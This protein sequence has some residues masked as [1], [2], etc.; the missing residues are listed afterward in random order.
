MNRIR[1]LIVIFMMPTASS[2]S[3]GSPVRDAQSVYTQPDGST[4]TVRLY[5]DEWLKICT[6]ADGCTVTKGNDGWWCYGIYDEEGKIHNS[7]YHIGDAAPQEII[8]ASRK[9]PFDILIQKSMMRRAAILDNASTAIESIRRQAVQTKTGG[10]TD[11]KGLALLVQFNDTE[12]TYGKEDFIRLLNQEG[13]NQTGSAKDYYEDQFGENWEFSFDVSEIITLPWPVS[14]YGMNDDD[15]QDIRPWEM[16]KD[17]CVAADNDIDFSQYD[18]DDDGKV[19]NVYIFYAG[20]SESEHTDQP[21][22]IWPH[23]YYIYSGTPG[24]NLVLDGKR[25]DRYACS[26]EITG[27]RSLTG[28]GSFCHEYGHTFGLMDL[29]D[30]DYDKKG[31]WAAGTW[32]STSLMDGGNYNNDSAT[33]PNFNCIERE[34]LGLSN[35]IILEEGNSY[36]IDPIHRNGL[37]FRLNTDTEG[38]YYLFE[39]RSNEGWDKYIGGRGMLVYHIDKNLKEDFGSYTA[40]KWKLNTINSDVT[41]QCADLIEADGRSDEIHSLADLQTNISGIFFP[42]ND[43]TAITPDGRP[44]LKF[45]SGMSS[46]LSITGI[47]LS[48]DN[49]ISF[50][51][52]NKDDV[53]DI[54]APA[55][56]SFTTFPSA[57]LI[58][59]NSSDT[60]LSGKPVVQWKKAS[61]TSYKTADAAEYDTGKYVCLIQGLESGNVSYEAVIRFRAGNSHDGKSQRVSFM[62]KRTPNITWPYI[63]INNSQINAKDGFPLYI[64][65][66]QE[67]E[68]I[69]WFYNG[70]RI[71]TDGNLLFHP[72]CNG[73]IK[74]V[75]RWKDGSCDT[76]IKEIAVQ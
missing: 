66:A 2:I 16:V 26:A 60:S 54:A 4:F 68:E 5:G 38:E 27:T 44:S 72:S 22:L 20:L 6:T 12:F 33:P 73:T 57:V 55:D 65:N 48:E 46:D 58:Y 42:Q 63:V 25:I 74:A 31:G 67:A 10:K 30:T 8:N 23:Q 61:E 51:V 43:V 36:M 45:W 34:M 75:I 76:I 13:Y 53:P 1:L 47:T 14:H 70:N 50:N 32:R 7:G 39:C 35:P 28:I 64:E 59:F 62:T 17:A 49:I 15:K 52:L 19:D 9:I 29:Y 56:I 71:Y 69:E 11:K 18:Q 21:D 24:I 40:S 41:H 3:Y 37:C